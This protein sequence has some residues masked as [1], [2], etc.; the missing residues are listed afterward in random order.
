MPTW[1]KALEMIVLDPPP[2]LMSSMVLIPCTHYIFS[3]IFFNIVIDME[4]YNWTL[5]LGII[6]ILVLE[7]IKINQSI[8]YK[9]SSYLSTFLK[10]INLFTLLRIWTCVQFGF[11]FKVRVLLCKLHQRD[12]N[13]SPLECFNIPNWRTR[14]Q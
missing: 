5:K 7:L 10:L 14:Q 13:S 4:F 12:A 1:Q 6:K 11:F 3:K 2:L 8:G 9:S